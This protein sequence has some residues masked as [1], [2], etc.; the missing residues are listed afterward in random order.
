MNN[1]SEAQ[2]QEIIEMVEGL[3]EAQFN[4]MSGIIFS[5]ILKRKNLVAVPASAVRTVIDNLDHMD[6]LR[7]SLAV[8]LKELGDDD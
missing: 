8:K 5:Q 6:P 4:Y 2:S 3:S 7:I 1:L